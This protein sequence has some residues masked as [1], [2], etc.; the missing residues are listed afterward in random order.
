GDGMT[1]F[2][3]ITHIRV[4]LFFR[5]S[6][7]AVIKLAQIR[8]GG[9]TTLLRTGN[10]ANSCFR[11]QRFHRRDEP[12]QLGK[13]YRADFIGR[14]AIERQLDDGVAPFPAKRFARKTFHADAFFPYIALISA[15]NLA[16]MA[17]RRSLPLAVSRPFSAVKA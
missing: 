13:H 14:F 10:N 5:K 1:A 17:S 3:E 8:T 12:L 11:F 9:K 6:N 2:D 4:A 16:L 15:A 7:C